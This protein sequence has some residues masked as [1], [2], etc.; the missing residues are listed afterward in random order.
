MPN[1]VREAYEGVTQA[2]ADKARLIDRARQEYT[3]A[4]TSAAGGSY[5]DMLRMIRALDGA[6][7][8]EQDALAKALRAELD[9]S[10]MDL[11]MPPAELISQV[12]AYTTL[13]TSMPLDANRRSVAMSFLKR[14]A[15][16]TG[17]MLPRLEKRF[18]QEDLQQ[19][20]V[21]EELVAELTEALQQQAEDRQMGDGI[22]GDISTRIGDARSN[23]SSISEQAQ[24]AYDR[25]RRDYETYSQPGRSRALVYTRFEATR[26]KIFGG[27]VM[28]MIGDFPRIETTPDPQSLEEMSQFELLRRR[29]QAQQNQLN[30]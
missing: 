2:R 5:E 6:Q 3:D 24:R 1:A 30:R 17:P 4:L 20:K 7:R 28:T 13:L 16:L 21:L 8:S 15:Y 27:P 26:E 25:Y 29:E 19:R 23:R 14:A 22:T 18:A 11:R 9:R 10:I 12:R